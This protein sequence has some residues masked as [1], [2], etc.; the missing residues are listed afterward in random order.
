HSMWNLGECRA[1]GLLRVQ[2]EEEVSEVLSSG[3]EPNEEEET[4]DLDEAFDE[5]EQIK[6]RLLQMRDKLLPP[7]ANNCR[8]AGQANQENVSFNGPET[9]QLVELRRHNSQLKCQLRDMTEHL[10]STRKELKELE[11]WRCLLQ[12][13]IQK[14]N[15]QLALFAAFKPLATHHFGLCIERW[16]QLKIHKVGQFTYRERMQ[17]LVNHADNSRKTLVSLHCHKSIRQQIRME[18]MLLRLFLHNLFEAMV[19]AFRFICGQM[20]V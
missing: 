4:T 11:S 20:N 18:L 1:L 12:T 15:K 14:M 7:S 3:S 19:S 13:R 16:E 17:T 6:Q 5:L 10:N 9:L 2:T 8:T